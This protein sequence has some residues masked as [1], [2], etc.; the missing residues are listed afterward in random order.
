MD[1]ASTRR[2]EPSPTPP[3]HEHETDGGPQTKRRKVRKG[4]RS[5]W[6]CRRRKMKC[7]FGSPADTICVSCQRRGAKC[8]DQQFPQQISTPLDR[9]L[10]MVDRVTRVEG[11]VEQLL[12]K[13]S[14]GSECGCG[15]TRGDE[16]SSKVNGPVLG[17]PGNSSYEPGS[18]EVHS[19]LMR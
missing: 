9:S 17:E 19:S 14:N 15:T 10:Q 1:A 5:C 8:V 3:D 2:H 12:K 7:I 16:K 6:E 13:T 18:L 4:T 11:L